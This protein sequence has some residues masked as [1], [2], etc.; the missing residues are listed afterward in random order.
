MFDSMVLSETLSDMHSVGMVDDSIH[1]IEALNT[2]VAMSVNT[3][4]GQTE[5]TV[6]SAVVAQG[7][8]MAPLEASLQVDNMAKR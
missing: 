4:Y 2:N 5:T 3:P 1:L 8:L 6:L 7:D